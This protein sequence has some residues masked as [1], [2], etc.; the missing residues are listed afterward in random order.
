MITETPSIYDVPGVYSQ[1]GGG[2]TQNK[3]F[4][5]R[6]TK[7]DPL[8]YIYNNGECKIIGS[9][10]SNYCS[11]RY[12]DVAINFN[13]SIEFILKLKK[14]PT[15]TLQ[16]LT[17]RINA[18]RNFYLEVSTSST[19]FGIVSQ[20]GGSFKYYQNLFNADSNINEYSFKYNKQN[21]TF[22][23]K[24]ND[25]IIVNEILGFEPRLQGT[26][27]NCILGG[28]A[29]NTSCGANGDIFFFND[30]KLLQDGV[31]TLGL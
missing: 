24:V 5:V 4:C 13:N 20:D 16:Y 31:D 7:G 10:N 21:N 11:F 29:A 18:G 30:C 17:N 27:D 19:E 6:I 14:I 15:S 3:N 9:N 1:G 28:V 25:N 8:T 26:F 12:S 23:F 2:G 22:T